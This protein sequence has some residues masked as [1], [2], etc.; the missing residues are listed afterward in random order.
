M[1]FVLFC[2]IL[3]LILANEIFL[4]QLFSFVPVCISAI[5]DRI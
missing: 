2:V 3:L 5:A 4:L 1:N